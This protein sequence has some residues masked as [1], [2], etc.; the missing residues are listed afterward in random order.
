VGPAPS[1]RKVRYHFSCRGITSCCGLFLLRPTNFFFGERFFR[2]GPNLLLL[3]RAPLKL[4][5][6]LS[7]L[8]FSSP[9]NFSLATITPHISGSGV[10]PLFLFAPFIRHSRFLPPCS[11]L[12]SS[13]TFFRFICSF[14]H[15]SHPFFSVDISVTHVSPSFLC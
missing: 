7:F 11:G 14:L 9:V 2:G 12:P 6:G 5:E 13:N 15:P 3:R 10:P 4:G 8:G 1:S